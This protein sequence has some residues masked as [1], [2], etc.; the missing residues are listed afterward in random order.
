VDGIHPNLLILLAACIA[1]IASRWP[2]TRLTADRS[3]AA[4]PWI[5]AFIV[6]LLGAVGLAMAS[7]TV[8]HLN[9][10]WLP[11]GQDWREFVVFALDIQTGGDLH[12]VPQ[13][14]P[15]YPWLAVL[16]ANAQGFPVYLG[17]MQLNVI[18]AGLLPAALYLLGRQMAP[19]AVAV[20]GAVLALHI[21]TVVAVLGPPTDYL[22]H[23]L[24][25]VLCLAAGCWALLRGGWVR[26]LMWGGALALL[27]AVTMKSLPVLLVAAPLG[28]LGLCLSWRRTGR[29]PLL[30]ALSWLL[31]MALIWQ[32]Y[33]GQKRWVQD[34]YTL[35]YNVYRTQVVVA[36]STGRTTTFPRDLGW[37]ESDE[38]QMGFWGV[39]RTTAWTHLPQTLTFLARGPDHNLPATA[40][41]ASASQGL[42]AALHL[43]HPAWLSLGLLGMLAVGSR[44]RLH[45][46]TGALGRLLGVTWVSGITLSHLMGLMS[47][48]YIPR[49][50]LVLLIPLPL[51]LLSGFAW[52]FGRGRPNRW[53][54]M[55]PLV[56]GVM[57]FAGSPPGFSALGPTGTPE[58]RA[59]S[60]NPHVDFW[61]W[62]DGLQS[63]D[64][65]IDL[66]GN[67][68][69]A[70]LVAPSGATVV[71]VRDDH[72][73]FQQGPHKGGRRYIVEPGCLNM[74][75]MNHKWAPKDGDSTRFQR[76]R[77]ALLEDTTPTRP[78][79]VI[80]EP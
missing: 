24:I 35:D 4:D 2:R 54:L 42:T 57:V 70:D 33:A 37:H 21:P 17:L 69:V 34:A 25:H 52:L 45:V 5:D 76:I 51:M 71:A 77:R 18:A 75:D 61:D 65:V 32:I 29:V 15:F 46:D 41:F 60:L 14:Y 31:P 10:R 79:S 72:T 23:G 8:D 38:K 30:S 67:R 59:L 55:L 80:R 27:M 16:L 13:R 9:P 73:R 12:P 78:L 19:R 74:G 6:T 53:W 43:G 62:R 49:Y 47:T 40:R 26:H 3:R 1:G 11:V 22:L 68:I 28:V 63:N 66:T 20:A 36:R 56:V 58:A 64:M 44:R 50:A 39:G 48:M 7:A